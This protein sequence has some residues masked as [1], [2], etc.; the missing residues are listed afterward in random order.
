MSGQR[1]DGW[2]VRGMRAEGWERWVRVGGG[3]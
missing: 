1:E 3:G 2:E